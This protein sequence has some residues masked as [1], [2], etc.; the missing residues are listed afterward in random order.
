MPQRPDYNATADYF[1][2]RANK[3]RRDDTRRAHFLAIAARYRAMAE[4][5][6]SAGSKN[7][8][9]MPKGELGPDHPPPTPGKARVHHV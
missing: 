2:A 6:S 1:E 8:W 7:L 3:K 9:S 5:T 4:R